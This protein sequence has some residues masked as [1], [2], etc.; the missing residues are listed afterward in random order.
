MKSIVAFGEMMMRLSPPEHLRF[1]QAN[2]FEVSYSGAEFNTLASLQRWGLSTQFVTKLPDNDFGNKAISEISRYQVGSQHIV[3]EG[4]RLGI[5][6]LEKGNA[7]RH[8]K[9]IYDRADSAVANIKQGEIDWE[10]VFANATGFHWSGITPGIS[11]EA[12][13]EC[14]LACK[15][16]KKMGLKISCDLNYR[17]TLWKW[18]KQPDEIL[19]EMLEITNV[20]LA[21]L[22]TLNKMLGKKSIDP[23]YRKPDTL[24]EYYDEILKACPDLEFLPTTLRYSESAS[25]QK[26]GGIMYA[27]GELITSEVKEVL[28]VVDRLGTGD[29]FMAGI[30][31]GI[32]MKMDYQEVL[33][34]AVATCAYKH[35]MSGDI[36]I[37]SLEEVQAIMKGDLS[38]LI[39]R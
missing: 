17:S 2:S 38:A 4:K 35:T 23:D 34:F 16:A 37:A 27:S 24:K 11:A 6:F 3:K 5:Y 12:A 26:I 20:I 21:D 36:N 19:P 15:T 28:P 13:R 10:K 7:I 9:V 39:K 22:A 8:S 14:L 31:Y 18:G 32:H 1:F 29:A 33:D 25:H 30:L